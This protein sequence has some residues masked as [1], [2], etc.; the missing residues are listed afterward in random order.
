MHVYALKWFKSSIYNKWNP[1]QTWSNRIW[2]F[3]HTSQIK[4]IYPFWKSGTGTLD[5][6]NDITNK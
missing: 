2:F 1:I 4:K 3:S 6:M 5:I